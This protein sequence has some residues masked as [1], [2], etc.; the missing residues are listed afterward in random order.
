MVTQEPYQHAGG[1]KES[2]RS[3]LVLT[4]GVYRLTGKPDGGEGGR[5]GAGA[6]E[7]AKTTPWCTK[8]T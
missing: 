2:A 3:Q 4:E 8:F 1:V 5:P 7:I 6:M